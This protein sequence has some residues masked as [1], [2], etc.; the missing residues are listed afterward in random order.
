MQ[1]KIVTVCSMVA[2]VGVF[3]AAAGVLAVGLISF[4]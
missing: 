4:R 1:T 3:F 2:E